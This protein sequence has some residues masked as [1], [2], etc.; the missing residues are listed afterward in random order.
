MNHRNRILDIT[1]GIAIILVVIGHSG[2]EIHVRDAI[3]FFHMPLFFFVSGVLFHP[4]NGIL[5]VISR[6]KRLYIPFVKYSLL[7]L[8]LSPFLYD[9]LISHTH[10][11]SYEEW[12]SSIFR[13]ITFRFGSVDLL[14]QYWFLPVLFYIYLLATILT[15]FIQ[16]KILLL[17]IVLPG[18]FIGYELTLSIGIGTLDYTRIMY[19]SVFFIL[20]HVCADLINGEKERL[21]HYYSVICIIGVT[22]ILVFSMHANNVFNNAILYFIVAIVGIAGTI[23][24]STMIRRFYPSELFAYLGKNTMTIY[25]WHVLVFK[26]VEL[27]LSKMGLTKMSHGFYGKYSSNDYFLLYILC[28]VTIP[29]GLKVVYNI[30]YNNVRK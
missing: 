26:L 2:I 25:T 29:I 5:G 17:L 18:Y 6:F 24:F 14:V 13:I 4:Q 16:H 23:S 20:G 1:K 30:V 8:F 12:I 3:Y 22:T 27:V 19:D 21:R 7:L 11:T 9:Y 10:L 28:G 15:S